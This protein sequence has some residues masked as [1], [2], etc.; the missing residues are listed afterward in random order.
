MGSSILWSRLAG[1]EALMLDVRRPCNYLRTASNSVGPA[2]AGTCR[3]GHSAEGAKLTRQRCRTRAPS[4]VVSPQHDDRLIVERLSAC[5]KGTERCGELSTECLGQ[6]SV[7][8]TSDADESVTTQFISSRTHSFGGSI[9]VQH[10]QIAQLEFDNCA[11]V[12]HVVEQAERNAGRPISLAGASRFKPAPFLTRGTV[13]ERWGVS[14]VRHYKQPPA[15]V[16]ADRDHR[17]VVH[18]AEFL[19]NRLIEFPHQPDLCQLAQVPLHGL[20]K[21]LAERR[22]CLSMAAHVGKRDPRDDAARAQR[23]VV[24]IAAPI[25]WPHRHRMH[26]CS[27]PWQFEQARGP[28]VTR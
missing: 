15:A 25:N 8:T 24:D 21:L 10:N 7:E 13:P 22:H 18:V 5:S 9:A 1:R 23:Y 12:V 27:Q 20:S 19:S 6:P 2:A 14:R 11:V 3:R 16:P 28:L 4:D 26:P 17:G